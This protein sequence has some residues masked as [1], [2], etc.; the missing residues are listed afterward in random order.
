MM[1]SIA[2]A[3]VLACEST[4]PGSLQPGVILTQAVD[5][6]AVG[7]TSTI[8]YDVVSSRTPPDTLDTASIATTVANP[9]V[10]T[11][12]HDTIT[13][14]AIGSTTLTLFALDSLGRDIPGVEAQVLVEVVPQT[15]ASLSLSRTTDT[16]A[17]GD[18]VTLKA[19]PLQGNGSV[20]A[21][22]TITWL[23]GNLSVATVSTAGMVTTLGA[24]IARIT[25]LTDNGAS[26]TATIYVTA[27]GQAFSI[28][29]S[30]ERP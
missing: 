24:G 11:V 29:P 28:K 20:S 2:T 15:I 6:V 18:T 1:L 19:T 26:A 12:S 17:L 30:E 5:T 23:S 16:L 14:R 13:G 27:P 21:G 8:A 10:A 4:A 25:A 9:L 22:H 3:A 7:A